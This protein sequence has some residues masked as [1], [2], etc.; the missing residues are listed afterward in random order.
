MPPFQ[1]GA[2][3]RSPLR[4]P[5][6]PLHAVLFPGG[7]LPLR[8]FEQ[9]Y[10]GMAK[11]CLRD[12]L[13]FGVCRI[14]RG[15]EVAKPEARDAI[16]GF[17]AIGTLATIGTWEMPQLGILHVTARGGAR[18]HVRSH[19]MQADGLIVAEA[20]PVADEPFIASG[21]AHRPLAQLLELLIDRI[22]SEHFPDER[23]FDDASWVGFRLAELLPLPLS[24]KQSMLEM[25][26][27]EV[28]LVV[29]QRFLEQHGLLQP[30]RDGPL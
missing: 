16:P 29:L 27:A 3:D 5:L 7:R 18:F 6:F 30:L 23:S 25:N 4:L 14:T 10:I 2:P 1:R 13:P 24:V 12:A 9:R 11:A 17:A 15:D 8:I 21:D 26:D 28:R 19:A 20:T 22:G